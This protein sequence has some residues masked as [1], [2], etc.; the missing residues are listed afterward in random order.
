MNSRAQEIEDYAAAV[1]GALADV[2]EPDRDELLEDLEEHLTEVAAESTE[3]L[4]ARLGVPE[5]YAA[6]LRAAYGAAGSTR[7]E[8]GTAR[9]SLRRLRARLTHMVE[10]NK[11]YRAGWDHLRE[12]RPAWWL[13]RAFLLLL[14]WRALTQPVR[15]PWESEDYVIL[16]ALAVGS[17]VLGVRGRD[18]GLSKPLRAGVGV[19]NMVAVGAVLS[20]PLVS[21]PDPRPQAGPQVVVTQVGGDDRLSGI[22]NIQPYSKE[23]RPLTGVLL[24]DQNGYPLQIPYEANGFEL[25]RARPCDGPPPIANSYPLPLR[26]LGE[27][28]P[29][30]DGDPT[31]ALDPSCVPSTNTPE[32]LP[33]GGP[34]PTTPASGTES[35]GETASPGPSTSG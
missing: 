5:S 9:H 21:G 28:D 11:G 32:P 17:V 33:S 30:P 26:P 35:P 31:A 34:R 4:V 22:S 7:A 6:E 29:F 25:K 18:R 8:R 24:Y 13:A 19:L 12:L 15:D 10:N 20:W 1:R 23:G 16:L 14:G 2:P 27:G 3:P